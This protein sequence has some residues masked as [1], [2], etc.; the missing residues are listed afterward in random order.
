MLLVKHEYKWNLIDGVFIKEFWVSA[1]NNLITVFNTDSS[2]G[3]KEVVFGNG[4]DSEYIVGVEDGFKVI[5]V[6]EWFAELIYVVVMG[7]VFF[8]V[9][10]FDWLEHFQ[11]CCFWIFWALI[12][13]V[14]K[15]LLF[16]LELK[17]MGYL[18]WTVS[19]SCALQS[20]CWSDRHYY[21]APYRDQ[22]QQ[23]APKPAQW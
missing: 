19:W 13:N 23:S 2:K 3:M 14:C 6:K 4:L 7:I 8:E 22:G 11:N 10:L 15:Q 12:K 21:S 9:F 17:Q 1:C 16:F 5:L 18:R 20:T